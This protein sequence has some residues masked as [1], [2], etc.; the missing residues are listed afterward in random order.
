MNKL[1][2]LSLKLLKKEGSNPT[3]LPQ[4]HLYR[5][6]SHSGR[7]PLL[8]KQGVIFLIKGEKKIYTENETISYDN[9]NY[10]VITVP[11]PLECQCTSDNK[12]PTI[13]LTLDIETSTLISL[14][15]M[16]EDSHTLK[17]I[18][19]NKTSRGLYTASCNRNIKNTLE[20]LLLCLQD[21]LEAKVLGQGII[22]EIIFHILKDERSNPLF[23]LATKNTHLSKVEFAL[24]E[25]QNNFHVNF[26]VESLA[27]SVNMS[28]SS[29][30]QSFKEVTSSSPI[31]YIKKVRLNKARDLLELSDTTVNEAALNV[32]YESTSQFSREFKRY[33]GVTPG[34]IKSKINYG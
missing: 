33:F 16:M 4:V 18:N 7:V 28:V 13:A 3:L 25:V 2:E 1:I 8:Y 10:L 5:S 29:F 11:M 32:G 20:R 30:H 15:N 34:S 14:I 12:E 31:Q 22:N 24:R 6:S 27:Q 23:S 17:Q 26:N 21:P 19:Q 9:N